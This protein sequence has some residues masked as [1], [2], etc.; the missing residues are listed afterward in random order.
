MRCSRFSFGHLA[1]FSGHAMLLPYLEQQPIYNSCNFNWTCW[2]GDGFP[3]N[4][5]VFN[6][7]LATFVCPSDGSNGLAGADT[8]RGLQGDDTYYIDNKDDVV[9][10]SVDGGTDAA[11]VG[12][13]AA[14]TYTLA[15][16]VENGVVTSGATV[17]VNLV[18]NDGNNALYGNAAA[19][20]L[21][22]GAGD[23]TLVGGTGNDTMVGGTGNDLFVVTDSGDVVT[24]LA[25]GGT[26]VVATNLATYVLAA[27]VENLT[28]AGEA[29]T[30]ATGN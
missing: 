15:A 14:G 12:F 20:G 7:R 5:T 18:G 25:G 24:E 19:N 9:D 28:Y 6:L 29:Q 27:N 11:L 8:L 23:D 30:N 26:D 17:A 1:T 21:T 16:N 13:A 22:G 10:E 3:I 4:S 2:W